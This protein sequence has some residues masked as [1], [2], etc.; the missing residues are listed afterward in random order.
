MLGRDKNDG[1]PEYGVNRPSSTPD[2]P[3]YTAPDVWDIG[4][5]DVIKVSVNISGKRW[6]ALVS[7]SEETDKT[8]SA[9]I[10][11]GIAI[12]TSAL[13]AKLYSGVKVTVEEP[14]G[15]VSEFLISALEDE[16][17]LLS[18]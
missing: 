5:E 16:H 12:E 4:D 14:N 10:R 1:I 8:I 11:R 3:E 18:S 17:D 15:D 9:C 7:R 13:G 6:L 2:W